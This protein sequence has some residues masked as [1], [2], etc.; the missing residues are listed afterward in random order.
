MRRN[1]EFVR[2]R[3][4][5]LKIM[6]HSQRIHRFAEVA[7]EPGRR[8]IQRRGIK[9][10]QRPRQPLHRRAIRIHRGTKARQ[11]TG[12][13]I[14][15]SEHL[16]GHHVRVVGRQVALDEKRLVEVGP[17]VLVQP[18][19]ADGRPLERQVADVMPIDPQRQLGLVRLR[20]KPLRRGEA[21]IDQRLRHP[22][23]DDEVETDLFQRMTK[24]VGQRLSR[25]GGARKIT[26]QVKHRNLLTRVGTDGREA[27]CKRTGHGA[28][29]LA[30][31][32]E[33]PISRSRRIIARQRS[34]ICRVRDLNPRPSVYKTAA[35]PLC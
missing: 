23:V 24:V 6:R 14:D 30:Q 32:I 8:K 17:I 3:A 1:A 26:C 35:L 22:V 12:P 20:V 34:K 13:L 5:L 29:L 16:V 7:V 15:T 21:V 28:I 18:R 27:G 19:M 2:V 10:Q 11:A 33:H 31:P 9:R 25:T 4:V